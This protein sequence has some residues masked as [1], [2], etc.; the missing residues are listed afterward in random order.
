MF[1]FKIVPTSILCLF[2]IFRLKAIFHFKRILMNVFCEVLN[3]DSFPRK[4]HRFEKAEAFFDVLL[5][6][7]TIVKVNQKF[8]ENYTLG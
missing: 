3:S 6:P 8:R 2:G 4:S 5:K 7:Y 1:E